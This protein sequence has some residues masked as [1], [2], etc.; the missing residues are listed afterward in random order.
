MGTKKSSKESH[1][2]PSP[3]MS[4]KER[5]AKEASSASAIQIPSE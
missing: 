3:V 5:L 1:P 4:V 2:S